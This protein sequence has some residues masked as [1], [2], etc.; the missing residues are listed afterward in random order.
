MTYSPARGTMAGMTVMPREL[1]EWSVDDLGALPDD[2]LQYELLDGVLLVSPGPVPRHQRAVGRLY[3]LLVA[4]CPLELEVF[5]TPPLDWQPDQKTSLQPDLLVV[6]KDQIGEQNIT[7][8]LVLAVEVLS[9]STRRKDQI[10]KRSKY[11]HVG[12]PSFWIVDPS[13]PSITCFDLTGGH[14]APVAHAEAGE[15]ITVTL[16]YPVTVSPSA[17]AD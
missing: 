5:L 16:P 9:P 13:E 1:A 7:A 12:V 4:A 15:S 2:G 17:L 8:N 10:L 6:G 14:Y 11:Q 3:S